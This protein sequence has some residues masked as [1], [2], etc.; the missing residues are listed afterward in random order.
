MDRVPAK[1]TPPTKRF[2]DVYAKNAAIRKRREKIVKIARSHCT[3]RFCL[4]V[5]MLAKIWKLKFGRLACG[6]MPWLAL[7]RAELTR[8]LPK[9]VFCVS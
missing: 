6:K 2:V 3:V 7:H 5:R 9:F 8:R 4:V 1:K